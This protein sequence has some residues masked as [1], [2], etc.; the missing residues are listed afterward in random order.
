MSASEPREK[1]TA[2][3]LSYASE[4]AE[5]VSRFFEGFTQLNQ[6][7]SNI[8]I[9]FDR[10]VI[11]AGEQLT[12]TITDSLDETEYL[13]IFLLGTTKKNFGWTGIEVGYFIGRI[14]LDI[15]RFG[16]SEREIIPIFLGDLPGLFGDILGISLNLESEDIS[17]TVDEFRL[18][19]RSIG[20]KLHDF[21]QTFERV[22]NSIAT[23]AE[24]RKQIDAMDRRALEEHA[25]NIA[26][27]IEMVTDSIVPN[28]MDA[29][30]HWLRKRIT[31]R[32]FE[33]YFLEFEFPYDVT[34][35][36]K[37]EDQ[38]RLLPYADVLK[39]FG[40]P[41]KKDPI[42][43]GQ[44]KSALASTAQKACAEI[45]AAIDRCVVSAISSELEI[46]N[47]QI[48]RSPY[49]DRVYRMVITRQYLYYDGRVTVHM[50]LIDILKLYFGSNNNSDVIIS[51]I[52]I[53]LKFRGLFLEWGAPY[54]MQTFQNIIEDTPKTKHFIEKF[55]QQ[56]LIIE[57]ESKIFNL[58]ELREIQIYGGEI[59]GEMLA[60]K[61]SAWKARRAALG[62]AS[63]LVLN[64]DEEEGF[65]QCILE[66]TKAQT[67]FVQL[68]EELNQEFGVRAIRELSKSFRKKR[69]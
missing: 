9:F 66:W 69:R 5:I 33:Q 43:W 68:S 37:I 6:L 15:E 28:I 29:L 38:A 42:T 54:S 64:H 23:L 20:T 22:F 60:E 35:S 56:L 27:R 10:E 19:Y 47:D 63:A 59:S 11:H 45:L 4:D 2:V 16:K 44:F 51:F 57:E 1:K 39:V 12:K 13:I 62:K 30:Y 18:Q 52:N 48:F 49:D 61:T 17:L 8:D 32:K 26:K 7:V 50:Y 53:S 41:D 21:T 34:Q 65:Q 58:D 3:F 55:M 67:D 36:K 14:K 46:D 25:Q 31:T 24:S 40:L